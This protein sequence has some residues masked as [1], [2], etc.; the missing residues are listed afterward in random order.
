MGGI[1]SPI[2]WRHNPMFN[3][4]KQC[5]D[6]LQTATTLFKTLLEE[7]DE[8]ADFALKQLRKRCLPIKAD[9]RNVKFTIDDAKKN[10]KE[11][12]ISD[13]NLLNSNRQIFDLMESQISRLND[14]NRRLQKE[15]DDLRNLSQAN[16]IST[17]Q[18][19]DN[20]PVDNGDIK[21]IITSLDNILSEY[22]IT[23]NEQQCEILDRPNLLDTFKLKNPHY[24]SEEFLDLMNTSLPLD[25][26]SQTK[27]VFSKILGIHPGKR[28]FLSCLLNVPDQDLIMGNDSAII[29]RWGKPR[30]AK[31]PWW[32]AVII[33]SG[34][35][36]MQLKKKLE[37]YR[38]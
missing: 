21:R 18:T 10:G 26:V 33:C 25:V 14:E 34:H 3:S 6:I 37:I 20:N 16:I 17:N 38:K 15:C 2:F 36:Q 24:S 23:L 4:E 5:E 30:Q 7:N 29:G 9:F 22:H 31:M 12:L 11:V 8:N 1:Y 35:I 32:G 27:N 19:I 13:Q 28:M